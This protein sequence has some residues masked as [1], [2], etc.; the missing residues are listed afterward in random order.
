MKLQTSNGSFGKV[1]AAAATLTFMI[2]LASPAQAQQGQW[3]SDGCFYASA[4]GQLIRQGCTQIVSGQQRYYDFRSGRWSV[5]T[6]QGWVDL[7]ALRADLTARYY[8][9][10]QQY[11]DAQA[12]AA[13][14]AA[15]NQ[16]TDPNFAA[17][18]GGGTVGG[19]YKG[20]GTQ[21]WGGSAAGTGNAQVDAIIGKMN[22]TLSN[23]STA[24]NCTASYNG[25]R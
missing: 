12:A 24:P 19:V 2:S 15:A 4:N 20:S 1:L 9:A 10:V 5:M 13:A 3:Y 17:N 8:S 21:G 18:Y 11:R 16:A 23:N 7:E 25:C 22:T 6:T 14:R